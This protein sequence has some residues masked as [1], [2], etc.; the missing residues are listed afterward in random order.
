MFQTYSFTL[1]LA[2]P[3]FVMSSYRSTFGFFLFFHLIINVLEIFT[4]TK[5][6]WLLELSLVCGMKYTEE[7]IELGSGS[8]IFKK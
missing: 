4:D 2:Q 8:K 3:T 1:L 7:A 6:T 5:H